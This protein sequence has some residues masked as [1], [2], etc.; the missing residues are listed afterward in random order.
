MLDHPRLRSTD[1]DEPALAVTLDPSGGPNFAE[2]SRETF[3]LSTRA[4][5]LV[6][7]DLGYDE[8][9]E[10][11][12]VTARTLLLAG[13]A[14]VPDQKTDPVETVQ[15]LHPLDGGKH[16]TDAEIDRIAT[17]LKNAEIEQRARW[18]A[19]A[20]VE[21]TR[22]GEVMSTDEIRTQRERMNGLRGIAKDL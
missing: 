18:L 15:R 6:V 11:A 2:P 13:G 7:D 16:P 9:E 19:E 22:L 8:R 21:D 12:S 5:A 20:L 3:V 17:Y 10:V 1:A 4:A 14:Y